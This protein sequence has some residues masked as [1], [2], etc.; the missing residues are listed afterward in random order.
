MVR[1]M[2]LLEILG[3]YRNIAR[4]LKPLDQDLDNENWAYP[5]ASFPT[6]EAI[7][8]YWQGKKKGNGGMCFDELLDQED[9]E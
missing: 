6:K 1:S 2:C 9:S 5:V 3:P 4:S 7:N 8:D